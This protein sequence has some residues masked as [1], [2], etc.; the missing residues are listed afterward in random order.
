MFASENK[1]TKLAPYIYSVPFLTP[2]FCKYLI[3]RCKSNGNWHSKAGDKRYS[4]QDIYLDVSMPNI[5]H[6]LASG[7]KAFIYPCYGQPDFS[8]GEDIPEPYTIFV[9]KYTMDNG[10]KNAKWT[11][12]CQVSARTHVCTVMLM[13][14]QEFS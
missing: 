6:R 3:S 13:L 12:E 11:K 4:T 8:F 9:L 7:L 1:L 10:P 2:E 14:M 5:Y